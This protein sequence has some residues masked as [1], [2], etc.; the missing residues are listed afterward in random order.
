M[1]QNDKFCQDPSGLWNSLF[2]VEIG[3]TVDQIKELMAL[4]TTV[5]K[6]SKNAGHVE[7]AYNKLTQALTRQLH[8]SN[9]NLTKLRSIFTP[10]Q[11]AKYFEWVHRFGPVC[12]KINL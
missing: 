12:V 10:L 2:C 1:S 3:C 7:K 11:L 8:Q 6:Q 4:R 9:D 5:K